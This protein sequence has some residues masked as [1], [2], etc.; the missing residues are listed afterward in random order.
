[1]EASA[2]DPELRMLRTKQADGGL[3][4][5]CLKHVDY[6]N[7]TGE[8]KWILWVLHQIQEEFGNLKISSDDFTNCGVHNVHDRLHKCLSLDQ[9]DYAK[10]LRT[11]LHP[12]LSSKATDTV[13]AKVSVCNSY[14]FHLYASSLVQSRPMSNVYIRCLARAHRSTRLRRLHRTCRAHVLNRHLKIPSSACQWAPPVATWPNDGWREPPRYQPTLLYRKCF[15]CEALLQTHDMLDVAL[16]GTI[17]A[18]NHV[19]TPS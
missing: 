19:G 14:T 1:M 2:I 11:I 8:E 4:L 5:V 7:V 13:Q 10:N 15:P 16:P 3:T 6:L 9:M 12:E 17:V 18:A